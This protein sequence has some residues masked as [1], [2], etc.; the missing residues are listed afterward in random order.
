MFR[1]G[2]VRAFAERKPTLFVAQRLGTWQARSFPGEAAAIL[3]LGENDS[4]GVVSLSFSPD[5]RLLVSG[6][7]DGTARVW[8]ARPVEESLKQ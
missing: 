4:G 6:G 5:V 1:A 2:K 7:I 8:D 3:R